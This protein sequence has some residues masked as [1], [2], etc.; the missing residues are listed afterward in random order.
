MWPFQ[1]RNGYKP[2]LQRAYVTAIAITQQKQVPS[3]RSGVTAVAVGQKQRLYS[4]V[5]TL[6]GHYPG[7]LK[8]LNAERGRK[9]I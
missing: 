7:F 1:K 2:L 6:I 9:R 3:A 8:L 5:R 4:G